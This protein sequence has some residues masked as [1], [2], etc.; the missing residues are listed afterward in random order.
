MNNSNYYLYDNLIKY[1]NTQFPNK[2]IADIEN[3]MTANLLKLVVNNLI[4]VVSE[5][6][7][8]ITLISNKPLATRFAR[9]YAEQSNFD[10][11]ISQ[12]HHKV[13][14]NIFAKLVLQ[15]LDGNNSVVELN[16]L[17]LQDFKSGKFSIKISNNNVEDVAQAESLIQ[18]NLSNYLQFF[19]K[20]G[21][22]VA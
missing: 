22:L 12:L 16:E 17:L 13:S 5:K 7:N 19:S 21:L 9:Y 6:P 8:Y 11:S 10:Y 20:A 4:K 1:L 14:L 2:N 15:Y 3:F 18:E